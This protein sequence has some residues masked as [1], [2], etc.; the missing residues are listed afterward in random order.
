MQV[1]SYHGIPLVEGPPAA[2]EE[3]RGVGIGGERDTSFPV[4][5]V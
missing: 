5:I 2:L 1:S 3:E 4:L